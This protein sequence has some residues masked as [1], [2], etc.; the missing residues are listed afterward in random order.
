[1][2]EENAP[3]IG[4]HVHCILGLHTCLYQEGWLLDLCVWSH[5]I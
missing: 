5:G 2:C 4:P 3:Q 1:M